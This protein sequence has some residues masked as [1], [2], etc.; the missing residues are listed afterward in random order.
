VIVQSQ[1]IDHV[2]KSTRESQGSLGTSSAVNENKNLLSP[3][4]TA[5]GILTA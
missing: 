5:A 1:D 2:L 4:T 3:P